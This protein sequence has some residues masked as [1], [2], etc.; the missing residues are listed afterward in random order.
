LAVLRPTPGS[1]SSASRSR[2]TSPPCFSSRIRQVAITFAAL[3]LNRPMVLMYCFSPSSPRAR[4]AAGVLA[5]GNRRRVALLTPTSVAWAD[6]ATATSNSNGVL[7]SSSVVGRGL[8]SRRRENSSCTSGFA[9]RPARARARARARMRGLATA[10]PAAADFVAFFATVF[11]AG[12]FADL[13]AAARL[14]AT[15]LM[16]CGPP[17][18]A[19]GRVRAPRRPRAAG[20]G[21]EREHPAQ[22]RGWPRHGA[23]PRARRRCAPTGRRGRDAARAPPRPCAA[24][25]APP[26]AGHWCRR[27]AGRGNPSAPPAARHRH[28]PGQAGRAAWRAGPRARGRA[29]DR[30]SAS[31][32][33]ELRRALFQERGRALAHVLGGEQ[34]GEL[35][36]LELQALLQCALAADHHRVEDR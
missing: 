35:R 1:A 14:L 7:Y 36:A 18:R 16:A 29:R 17:R 27:R 11:A 8:S 26:A 6:S 30:S 32:V 15:L 13:A 34:Q 33:A 21:R 10:L 28:R 31:A 5:T 22:W 9:S 20:Q 24:V 2:G 19:H 25:A 23:G 3:A 4:I 12:F